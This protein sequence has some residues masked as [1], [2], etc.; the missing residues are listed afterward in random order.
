MA[1]AKCST[2]HSHTL[3]TITHV[4]VLASYALSQPR[5]VLWNVIVTVHGDPPCR[6]ASPVAIAFV[7]LDL[8]DL[9]SHGATRIACP[10]S[11]GYVLGLVVLSCLA[12]M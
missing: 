5:L 9:S 10:G 7:R 8:A 6:A 3:H 11:C 4:E 2:E 1:T 12:S